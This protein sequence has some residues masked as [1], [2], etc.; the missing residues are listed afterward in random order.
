MLAEVVISEFAVVEVIREVSRG[1]GGTALEAEQFAKTLHRVGESMQGEARG[2]EA[3]F[4]REECFEIGEEG[5]V[6]EVAD[7]TDAI[8]WHGQFLCEL[9]DTGSFHLY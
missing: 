9:S 7:C 2:A 5:F 8:E 4:G 1:S 3:A 6:G